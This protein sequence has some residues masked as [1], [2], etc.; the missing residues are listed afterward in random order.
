MIGNARTNCN[1]TGHI[2]CFVKLVTI[3]SDKSILHHLVK[4]DFCSCNEDRRS[5]DVT[6]PRA[7]V[8]KI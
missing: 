5:V 7:T 6:N 3:S 1:S 4:K 2:A 8:I